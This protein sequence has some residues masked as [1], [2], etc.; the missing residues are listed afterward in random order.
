MKRNAVYIRLIPRCWRSHEGKRHVSTVPVKLIR[1]TNDL[2]SEHVDSKF[3]TAAI[4]YLEEL[5]SVLGPS[6]V[7]FLNKQTPLMM[8]VEYRIR[9]PD[10]DWVVAENHKLIP[11]V[12][13]FIEIEPE[14][15]GDA[16]AV[17]YSGP[18]YITIRSGKHCSST[19]YG[20]ARDFDRLMQCDEFEKFCK[21]DDGQYK[22]VV[23]TIS[24]GGP[25][26]NPRLVLH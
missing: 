3:C 18:T 20:H 8:H 5:A 13:A 12:Y 6:E 10:H 9:L 2:H 17:T 19:A 11:S 25:D 14:K 15:H 26:K 22:S 23:I 1:A 24:D 21:D 16:K 7:L 4:R